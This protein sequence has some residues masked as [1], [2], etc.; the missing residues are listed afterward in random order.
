[1]TLL[2][3]SDYPWPES[4]HSGLLT[5]PHVLT[6]SDLVDG[7][8]PPDLSDRTPVA[9]VGSNASLTVLRNKLGPLLQTGLPIAV[10]EVE[11][12][13]VGHSGHVSIR[14][15]IAAAPFVRDASRDGNASRPVTLAWFDQAQ[16]AAIDAT[17]PTYRRIVLPDTMPCLLHGAP[18]AGVEVYES[19]H[20]V[21]GEDGEPLEL[22]SQA[23]VRAWLA[24]RLP[25]T[26]AA[27]L[28]HAQFADAD[29][30]EQVRLALIEAGLV[31]PSGF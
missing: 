14:G 8:V 11:R 23:D 3:P 18:L 5:R 10:A 6:E 29:R 12:L 15:Y 13:A 25:T 22:L 4:P 21:L 24:H 2:P 19:R 7:D 16:L 30:R 31:V 17:E 28:D 20:G 26:V 27:D 9:A 1:M